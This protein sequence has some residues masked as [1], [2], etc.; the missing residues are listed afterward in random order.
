M[1]KK[2]LREVIQELLA[3]PAA[4]K[5]L[6]YLDMGI[7]TAT[8]QGAWLRAREAVLVAQKAKK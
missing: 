1:T 6:K 8:A 2:E 4:L 7:G 3:L 5:E